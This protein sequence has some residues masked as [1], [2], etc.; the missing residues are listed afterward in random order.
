MADQRIDELL[1]GLPSD[2]N[3]RV[4]YIND[5]NIDEFIN[6]LKSLFETMMAEVVG[7]PLELDVSW[8]PT[9]D[10][11]F[12]IRQMENQTSA[13]KTRTSF[14]SYETVKRQRQRIPQVIERYFGEAE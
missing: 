5:S 3:W 6:R 1:E 4:G 8:T 11:P 13:P 9:T 7:Q 2:A 12:G 10:D 14:E